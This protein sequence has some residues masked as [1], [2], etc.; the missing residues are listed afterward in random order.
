MKKAPFG[1][2]HFGTPSRNRTRTAT[3]EALHDIRFTIGA[4]VLLGALRKI[5]TFNLLVRSELLYPLSY[6]RISVCLIISINSN[7]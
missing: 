4:Y 2:L 1:A 5:R 7:R 6:K 3:F